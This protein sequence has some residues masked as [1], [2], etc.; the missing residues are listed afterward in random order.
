MSKIEKALERAMGMRQTIKESGSGGAE[1]PVEKQSDRPVFEVGAAVVEPGSVDRHIICFTDPYSPDAE[2]YRKL[3]AR[4]L[5]DTAE[6]FRNIIMATSA[7]AGE[8]KTITAINLAIAIA[9]EIDHTVLLV[10]ADLRMPSIHKYLGL[11]VKHGLSDY[12]K[13][14]AKLPEVLIKT[15][16]GKLVL[17]PSGSPMENPA[18]LLSSDRMKGLVQELKNRY[19]DRYVIFDS[20][21]LLLTADALS[22]TRYMDGIIMVV[23]ADRTPQSDAEKALALLKSTPVLGVVFNNVP[24]YL[25]NGLHS[26]YHYRYG[27]GKGPDGGKQK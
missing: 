10:D 27:N 11:T 18:E 15:G 17:L 23:Q 13:G 5:R 24:Q 19:K 21:P 20:S 7:Q 26:Y 14:D 25:S 12:L 1:D 2:Q 22:L 8:G 3:R 4:I 16:I 9:Q 6:G